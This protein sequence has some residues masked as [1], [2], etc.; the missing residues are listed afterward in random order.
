MT[1]TST[2]VDLASYEQHMSVTGRDRRGMQTT[3]VIAKGTDA[4]GNR[5]QVN[6]TVST[7]HYGAPSKCYSTMVNV[8]TEVREGGM[9]VT[10][11]E[12]L[13]GVRIINVPAARFSANGLTT[14]HHAAMSLLRENCD[15]PQIVALFNHA[16]EV[17]LAEIAE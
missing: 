14:A 12:P 10:T 3:I 8:E 16:A 13:R 4:R 1:A 2:T 5:A 15:S 17:A 6:V 11:G 7:R 9:I